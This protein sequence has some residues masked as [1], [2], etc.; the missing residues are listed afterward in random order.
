VRLKALVGA[1]VRVVTGDDDPLIGYDVV[2]A[3]DRIGS[4]SVGSGPGLATM[5]SAD[6]VWYLKKRRRSGW[7]FIIESSD[8]QQAGS[9][10]GRR[11]LPGGMISVSGAK[12]LD[13]RRSLP[14]RWRLQTTDKRKR[15]VDIRDTG[16]PGAPDL[17]LTIWSFPPGTPRD[18]HLILLTASA[19]VIAERTVAMPAGLTG[20]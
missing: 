1:S 11:W 12:Q 10:A 17:A 4:V 8:G 18:Q 14:R 2:I 5:L 3:G 6:A 13:L 15:L 20:P 16:N 19:I 9:Y 7:D